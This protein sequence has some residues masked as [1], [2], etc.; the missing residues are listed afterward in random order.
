MAAI[1][2]TPARMGYN[3]VRSASAQA[4][5]GQVDWIAPPVYAKFCQVFLNWTATG[6]TTPIIT[7]SF[8]AA[9]PT[10]M[11]DTNVIL[12]AEAAAFT[13]ITA[14]NQYVYDIG[15]GVTGIANDVTSSATADSYITLNANL[16]TI[17]G[18]KLLLERG[19][20]D[21]TYTYNL[22][23]TFRA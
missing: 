2:A 15:P 11:V 3:L 7:V 19:D 4:T 17:M 9:D 8:F 21:E 13:G 18:L 16:P 14:V 1:V 6:G 12:L 22:S 10:A 20:A 5:T 23:A